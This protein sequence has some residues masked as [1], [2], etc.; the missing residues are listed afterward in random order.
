M[1]QIITSRWGW[2]WWWGGGGDWDMKK[3]VYD[4]QN[5]GKDAFDYENFTNT[6]TIPTEVSEL[7]NDAWYITSSALSGYQT[8][9]NLVTN[10]TNPDDTHYPSAKAVSDAITSS[11]GWDMLKS[12]YDPNNVEANAFDYNNFINT[13]TIPTVND[14]TLKIQK[15]GT[16]V[17]TF[18]ANASA[19]VTA[20]ISVPTKVSE[21]N[22]DS[23][24]VTNQVD[25]TAYWS[26]WDWKTTKAPSQNAVYDKISAMDT[27]ISSKAADS[28]VVKLTWNQTIAW[29]KT[30]S[31]SPVV[32]SKTT[33]ATSSGTAIA[34]EA[35][36]KTVADGV[37][38]INGMISSN[39][40]SSNK[41]MDKNYID[42]SINSVT[43]YYITKNAQGDQWATYAE[44]AAATVFYSGGVQ[45]TPTK[46]D[47]TIV[48]DDENHDNATTRYI[49]NSGWEYQ[50]TVNETALTQAQLDAL[51]SWITAGK[52]STYDWYAST[53]SGKQ[54]ALTL[55]AT[56][57]QWHLVTWWADNETLVDGWAVPAS[58][59]VKQ[60]AYPSVS[61]DITTL[62]NWLFQ[63]NNATKK[64][65][66][67]TSWG[68]NVVEYYVV[69]SALWDTFAD[70][71]EIYAEKTT[72]AGTTYVKIDYSMPDT[73]ATVISIT[74]STGNFFAPWGTA[75]TGYVV[76]KTASGY[77]WKAPT[78]W[79][80]VDSAS[81]IQLTKI[82]AGTQAQYEALG[83][84]DATT[85]YLTI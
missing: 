33:T 22:N 12:V 26:G 41:L 1:T 72:S 56:P 38:T 53:I 8:T 13:P 80:E 78:W 28:D 85:V 23:W 45:R 48:L 27:T 30:F 21:L 43:A 68:G 2:Q 73:T 75:T 44:L 76:T 18:T 70:E 14:A 77:E 9:S 4:P 63:W 74:T 54:D 50:Y 60:F 71:G 24:F 79:I 47:Y 32:P 58:P 64:W 84:Y 83:S 7:D 59:T 5:I 20:D 11:G 52:V 31:T 39:A 29:T 25:D 16:D 36:V 65:A 81:P 67:L 35:Q 34:T 3:A 40:S 6:P 46:N 82:W 51:N 69:V 19:G 61:D 37:A 10:L 66:I 49:Y 17:A 57:T 42:D 55:P 62:H 15:N